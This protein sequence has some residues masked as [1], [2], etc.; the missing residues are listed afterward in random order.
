MTQKRTVKALAAAGVPDPAGDAR[1]LFDWAYEQGAAAPLDQTRDQPNEL[2]L[3]L[4]SHAI[5]QRV[6][7]KPVS[8]I[9]GRRAFWR[10][11]FE[12]TG[13][14]LDPRPDTETLVEAALQRGFSRV[15]DLGTG[16]GCILLS[17][18]ADRPR[19]LGV[20]TDLSD[21]AL[22][23]AT[24]NASRLGVGDRAAFL[25]SNW[26]SAVE[27]GFDLIVSNPPYIAQGEMADLQ[28]EVRDH[29]PHMALTDGGDGLGAYRAIAAGARAHMVPQGRLLLEIGPTQGGA[30]SA[31]LADAGFRVLDVLRDLD[32]RDRVVAAQA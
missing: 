18:L 11:D 7:R 24:R 10:H 31:I 26:F 8:Q 3:E 1:R 30:V 27:G 17:L 13:D 14:V 6:A 20:G 5:T 28:P 29:E 16:S 32:H 22:K 9:I 21:A 15:L 25:Q 4:F 2:T 12:V 23:V 19:A